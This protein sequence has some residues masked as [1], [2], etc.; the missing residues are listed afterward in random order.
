MLK[1][2][3]TGMNE[4][5]AVEVLLIQ[6]NFPNANCCPDVTSSISYCDVTKT[7]W[8]LEFIASHSW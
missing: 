1:H 6:T 5:P 4:N 7:N 3:W 8:V 2:E